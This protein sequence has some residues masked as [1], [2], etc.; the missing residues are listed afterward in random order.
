MHIQVACCGLHCCG[1]ALEHV[2]AD[3]SQ[4]IRWLVN[5]S[6]GCLLRSEAHGLA[7]HAMYYMAPRATKWSTQ[8][9]SPAHSKA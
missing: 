2:H 9:S 6:H 1:A 4:E 3:K 8:G 5:R 7:V